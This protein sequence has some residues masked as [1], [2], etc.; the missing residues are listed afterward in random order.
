MVLQQQVTIN[1][2]LVDIFYII[3][4]INIKK[5][6]CMKICITPKTYL[7]GNQRL[8]S[9]P[10]FLRRFKHGFNNVK[11]RE[12]TGPLR[13]APGDMPALEHF[14]E[15]L[16][17]FKDFR[18]FQ[19]CRSEKRSVVG[20]RKDVSRGRSVFVEERDIFFGSKMCQFFIQIHTSNVVTVHSDSRCLI[21]F[22]N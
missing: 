17:S 14:K 21:L 11:Q 19:R 3:I 8:L 7:L 10:F 12:T 18:S 4:H 16:R 13:F 9:T 22:L 1:G 6:G 20:I 15:R 2:L 5:N